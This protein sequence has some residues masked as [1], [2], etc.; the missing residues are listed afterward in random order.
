[1]H[2]SA[3]M[4]TTLLTGLGILLSF[5]GAFAWLIL[6]MDSFRTELKDD[7]RSLRTEFKDDLGSLRTELKDDLGSLPLKSRATS[8]HSAPKSRATSG[9]SAPKSRA[10]SVAYAQ[11]SRRLTGISVR[12]E[13]RWLDWRGRSV[14]ASSARID[15]VSRSSNQASHFSRCPNSSAAVNTGLPNEITLL[16]SGT[17]RFDCRRVRWKSRSRT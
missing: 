9:H 2:M 7:I 15:R 5:A 1:M 14:Q 12:S 10:T 3:E 16:G 6:R 13:F 17:H 8:G 11:T 4:L